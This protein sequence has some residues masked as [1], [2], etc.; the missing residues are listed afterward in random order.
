MASTKIQEIA[1][2]VF[3]STKKMETNTS[4]GVSTVFIYT[5]S[6]SLN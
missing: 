5:V 3:L 6:S 1:A 2:N 4:E